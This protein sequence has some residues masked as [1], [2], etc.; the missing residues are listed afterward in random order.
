[1]CPG[2]RRLRFLY[3]P[4]L[5]GYMLNHL[6]YSCVFPV[7]EALATKHSVAHLYLAIDFSCILNKCLFEQS[8][9]LFLAQIPKWSVYTDVHLKSPN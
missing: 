5:Q 9:C 2:R 6:V 7:I 4:V 1:M 8:K 3:Y